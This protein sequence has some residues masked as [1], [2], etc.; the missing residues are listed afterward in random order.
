MFDMRERVQK[1]AAVFTAVLILLLLPAGFHSHHHS[2]TLN[3]PAGCPVQIFEI[4]L[5]GALTVFLSFIL[6]YGRIP[7]IRFPSTDDQEF[8]AAYFGR[9]SPRAP[10][11]PL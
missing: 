1:F 10:P 7:W 2:L 3:E 6:L 9:I 8:V 11:I 4:S 5:L